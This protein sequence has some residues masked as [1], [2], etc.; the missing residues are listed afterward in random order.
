M[1][2]S[3]ISGSSVLSEQNLPHV[4][5]Q[6]QEESTALTREIVSQ[7]RHKTYQEAVFCGRKVCAQTTSI[8]CCPFV[9]SCFCLCDFSS[10][11]SNCSYQLV[12]GRGGWRQWLLAECCPAPA[13]P[14]EDDGDLCSKF[15]NPATICQPCQ[16]PAIHYSTATERDL[17]TTRI[18]SIQTLTTQKSESSKIQS[19]LDAVDPIA[20]APVQ[21]LMIEYA[22]TATATHQSD[23]NG[24]PTYKLQLED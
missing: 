3:H 17:Y 15:L 16:E 12:Q 24:K 20:P 19:L 6:I 11:C 5:Q 7:E 21:Q 1:I 23:K 8:L 10:V 2:V 18:S 9:M 13:K 22:V 14:A 4:K